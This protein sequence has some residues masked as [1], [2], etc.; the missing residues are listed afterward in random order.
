VVDRLGYAH[1]PYTLLVQLGRHPEGVLATDR[2]QRV[3]A[4]RGQVVDDPLHPV[5]DLERVGAGRAEDGPA[6]RE[7]APDRGHVQGPGQV[8]QRSAPAVAVADELVAVGADALAHDGP[9]DRVEARAVATAGEH[10]DSHDRIPPGRLGDPRSHATRG[11]VARR[12]VVTPTLHPS[13]RDPARPSWSASAP[14]CA[15]RP[16][17][18]R[19]ALRRAPAGRAGPRRPTAAAAPW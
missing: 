1:D 11:T 10:T 19:A 15:A 4:V 6:S 12:A 5:L 8:L 16:R 7:D 3:D 14:G 13:G 9:D 2:Y 17:A 18:R